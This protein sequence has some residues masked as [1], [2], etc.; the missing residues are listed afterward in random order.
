LDCLTGDGVEGVAKGEV[1]ELLGGLRPYVKGE[2]RKTVSSAA[3]SLPVWGDFDV[4]VAGAGTSGAAAGVAAA[5]AGAKTLVLEYLHVLGG[6]GTDGM[7]TGYYAG[8]HCGF[9]EEFKAV[10]RAQTAT[11]EAYRRIETWRR[12]CR[13]AGAEIWYGAFVAGAVVEN[14]KVVG[15]VVVTPF[16]RGIVTGRAIIDGTGNSDVAAAAGAETQ[17]IS[18]SE[19]ALQSAGQAPHRL[20]S[21]SVNSDFGLVNDTDAYDLWLFGLRSRAG[22]PDS[23]DLQQLVDSRERRRI[24]S[25]QMV[26]GWD[27]VRNRRYGDVIVR[28]S[29]KQDSHGYLIDDYGAVAERDGLIR[30]MV[31]LLLRTMLPRGL[32]GIAVIGIGKGVSRDVVPFTRMQADLMNEGYAVGLCAAEAAKER[33]GDFRKIDIR[34]VQRRLIE[35]GNLPKEVLEWKDVPDAPTDAELAAAVE[36]VPDGFKG[37]GVVMAAR[38]RAIPFLKTA[39]A[40][41]KTAEAKLVYAELLGLCGDATGAKVLVGTLDGTLA[42]KKQPEKR[43][44][45]KGLTDIGLALA[46]GRTKSAEAVPVIGRLIRRVDAE[47]T[48]GEVR[49]A[50]LAAEAHGGAALAPELAAALKRPGMSG[51][52]RKSASELAPLGGYFI[53]EETDRCLKE[54]ALARALFACGDHEGLAERTLRAYAADPRGVFAEHA[55]RVLGDRMRFE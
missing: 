28:A 26:M 51:W 7:I 6:V 11:S 41:A 53:S 29:S 50:T 38:E 18:S 25:D 31:N 54:L 37:S 9:T 24:V 4:I 1:R 19:L 42:V 46:L 35:K 33:A 16:G 40:M 48:V 21:G 32:A 17:F 39:F 55:S 47:S 22:A 27:V 43:C 45:G 13:D 36:T 12:M 49:M 23:W 10:V 15:V 52:S 20:F 14:G 3:R 5:R 8:N 44:Y 30:P 34:K 2:K